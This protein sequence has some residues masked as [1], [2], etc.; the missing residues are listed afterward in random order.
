MLMNKRLLGLQ[1]MGRL[2][3]ESE[4]WRYQGRAESGRLAERPG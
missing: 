1:F 2:F 3:V 4:S